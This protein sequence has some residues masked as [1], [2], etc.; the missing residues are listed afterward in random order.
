MAVLKS[1]K[2]LNFRKLRQDFSPN[3]LREGKSDYQDGAVIAANIVSLTGTHVRLS[4]RV[5]GS[6]DNCY[7]SE[8]EID[9][10]E[11]EVVD[12]NC[13]CPYRYDCRHLAAVLFHLEKNF[14]AAIV[15]FSKDT[16]LEECEEVD[17]EDKKELR[18]AF[19]E[20]ESK[21]IIRKG[22][23]IERQLLQEYTHSADVLARSPFF[24][25]QP[26]PSVTRA[27]LVL[28]FSGDPKPSKDDE[29]FQDVHLAL[30][31]PLRSKPLNV[32]SFKQF[33]DCVRYRE[34]INIGGKTY[35]FTLESFDEI[36]CELIKMLM[37]VARFDGEKTERGGRM[38]RVETEAFGTLLARAYEMSV[39]RKGKGMEMPYLYH[40]TLEQPLNFSRSP[41]RLRFELEY[42][43]SPAAKIL[44]KPL[45]VTE[46]GEALTC[47]QVILFDCAK[48]GMIRDNTYYQFQPE[49]RRKHLHGLQY[50]RD[51]TIPEPLFGTF[52]EVC[53]P[54]M[55]HFAEMTNTEKLDELVTL[56]FVEAVNASCDIQYLHGELEAS[57][58]FHYGEISV[59]GSAPQL[60]VND[61]LQFV[62]NE[63]VLSR[64]LIEEQ[65]ITND[66]FQDF[67]YSEEQ[68][69]YFTKSDKK[70]VEFM[71]EVVPRNQHRVQFNCP[72]N[73]LEQFVYDE[74]VF[75]L[76]LKPS[77]NVG[78]YSVKLSVKGGL[79]GVT[80]DLLWDCLSSRR[81]YIELQKK[82]RGRK[83]SGETKG[84]GQ[85]ILVLDLDRLAPIVQVFD[86]IGIQNLDNHEEDRPLWTLASIQPDLFD[87]L[88]INFEIAPALLDMQKQML[89]QKTLEAS[90]IPT[91]IQGTLRPYQK[92]GVQWLERLKNM[93]LGGVL[94]DD[95]GLGKTL[96]AMTV[97]AQQKEGVSLIV[98][99]TSLIYNWE[100][101]F[102][103]FCP[104]LKVLP[105]DGTPA[106]RKKLI[107]KAD[108]YDVLITSY[109]LLQKDIEAYSKVNF[110]YGIL[111][112]AQHIK[113][114]GTRNA[115]SV[116]MINAAHRLILTGTPLENSLEDIWSLFDYLMPGL[117]S[118]YDRF[119]EKYIRGSGYGE[120]TQ[121]ESLRKKLSPF[122]LR[123]MKED[124]L[125]DLPP[126]S[127]IVYH[128]H[129][130]STQKELYRSYAKSAREE[131]SRLV[132]KE[133]FDKVQIHV[134]A[135]LTRLKQ[136][137]CHPAIFAKE[138]PELGDS[139][140]YDML[141]ELLQNLL[142]SN[143][144]TV[145]FSQYTRMLQIVREDLEQMG[146]RFC[147]LDGSSKNRMSIVREFNEDERVRVFLVS[148]KAGGAGL[149]LVGADTVIHY[150]LWWNP[151]V[152]NQ[153]TDRVHRM[154]QKRSV[155]S[156]KLVTMGSIEEKIL[157]L[158]NR[159]KGLVKEVISSDEEAMSKLT[160]EEVLE[161]LQ[162]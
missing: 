160:W 47:E 86:E 42:L 18:K 126:V 146:I 43:E 74:T 46:G 159:K 62:T 127:H 34:P 22:K 20:A 48:P 23:V 135:T 155:S 83:R 129:L 88:P 65:V 4:S 119:V 93:Y 91:Q 103:R 33:I 151:A 21:E 154:G 28:V 112:E 158:Q 152:E 124:V 57:L 161:L 149:N 77:K 37:N 60:D 73:L 110:C 144:K 63:G 82:P 134:L 111:D 11:S 59:A 67:F 150:D 10:R 19:K 96:Q 95:M 71:T 32:P 84:T 79:K 5:K 102:H 52:V 113:N 30:R 13:D 106:A 12:S 116:K 6:Y 50:I 44:L 64:N 26:E 97:L 92:E 8:V 105:I 122:I 87:E 141:L 41:L 2:M 69:H 139:A 75:K 39:S 140:K 15:A 80:L 101:E 35:F 142:E 61:V 157:E 138:K 56:P 125:D 123:R 76:V 94:A 38:A 25:I 81:A 89:G 153:A 17:E 133:G 130:S 78:S 132:D 128:C 55:L 36:G 137:C 109:T 85:R 156:Y 58:K 53:V 7:E 117:L 98:C 147:Y 66:L 29:R 99:P 136:I 9:R 100:E 14:D 40:N 45:I 115:K 54:E 70:I 27:E 31:L 120:K 107:A 3:V 131:L 68:G 104:A 1:G 72:E 49:I 90:P 162:T 16:D 51:I 143:H 108:K 114:R 121:L 118:T 145:I 148:L 24:Q